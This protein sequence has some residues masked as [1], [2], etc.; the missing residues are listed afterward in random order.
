ML[1]EDIQRPGFHIDDL[2]KSLFRVFLTSVC[3][4]SFWELYEW[5]CEQHQRRISVTIWEKQ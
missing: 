5:V 3:L 4:V 1:S 2:E